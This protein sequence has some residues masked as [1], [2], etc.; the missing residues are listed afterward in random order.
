MALTDSPEKTDAQPPSPNDVA[1]QQRESFYAELKRLSKSPPGGP[2]FVKGSNI[3]PITFFPA[4]PPAEPQV[5]APTLRELTQDE[6]FNHL[7]GPHLV[8]E[9]QEHQEPEPEATAIKEPTEEGKVR[10]LFEAFQRSG[11]EGIR[12]VLRRRNEEYLRQQ[13]NQKSISGST[14]PTGR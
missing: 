14:E 8:R 1:K 11:E 4:H 2:R 12:E 5:P 7:W 3:G 10:E 13:R 6:G 9:A